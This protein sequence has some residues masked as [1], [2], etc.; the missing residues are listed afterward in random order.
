[1]KKCKIRDF[2]V[3]TDITGLKI[4]HMVVIVLENKGGY[5]GVMI[6]ESI[7]KWIKLSDSSFPKAC[8]VCRGLCFRV[9]SHQKKGRRR[10]RRRFV[11]KNENIVCVQL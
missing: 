2:F 3:W 11:L 1:M 7:R 5:G 6:I 9:L 10:R 4:K 8:W